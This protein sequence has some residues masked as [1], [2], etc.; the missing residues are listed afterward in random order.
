MQLLSIKEVADLLRT[1]E[2]TV[3]TWMNRKQIPAECIFRCGNLVRIR[4]DKFRKWINGD[5]CV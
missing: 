5:E 2:S 4:Q 3:R 1:K